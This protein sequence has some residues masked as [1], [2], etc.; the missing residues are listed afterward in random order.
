[1]FSEVHINVVDV[2]LLFQKV[3]FIVPRTIVSMPITPTPMIS[4][5][6]VGVYVRLHIMIIIMAVFREELATLCWTSKLA[7]AA[8]S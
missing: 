8:C 1:M 4:L 7:T 3:D 5:M 2:V 6:K